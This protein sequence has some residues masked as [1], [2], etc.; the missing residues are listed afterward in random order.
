MS[1]PDLEPCTVHAYA[2]TTGAHLYRL[3]YSVAQWQESIKQGG[4]LS[5]TVPLSREAKQLD[6]WSTLRPWK[7]MLALQRSRS[8]IHAGPLT[9]LQWDAG[10]RSLSMTCGGGMT[11]LTK[12]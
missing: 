10:S 4:S 9:D 5:V 3:P 2:I 12:R 7:C 11:L 8:V 1:L 6:L